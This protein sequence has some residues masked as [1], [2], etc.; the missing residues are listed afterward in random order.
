MHNVFAV[1]LVEGLR[2]FRVG[3]RRD[4]DNECWLCVFPKKSPQKKKQE[5]H[6]KKDNL[7]RKIVFPPAFFGGYILVCGG[8]TWKTD[9]EH[10]F[11]KEISS[12]PNLHC[13]I[14][15]RISSSNMGCNF[16]VQSQE[17]YVLAGWKSQVRFAGFA[18]EYL[19]S[20]QLMGWI[21]VLL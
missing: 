16:G 8:V 9:K 19:H 17:C 20:T 7:N 2:R 14:P 11:E 6:L 4:E 3:A 13:W 10:H 15:K 1:T 5:C 12:E 21:A 18:D